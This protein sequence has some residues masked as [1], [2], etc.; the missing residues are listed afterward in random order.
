M[1]KLLILLVLLNAGCVNQRIWLL[2]NIAEGLDPK[3]QIE[4]VA[5]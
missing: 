3:P 1:K 5:E 2:E 4:K